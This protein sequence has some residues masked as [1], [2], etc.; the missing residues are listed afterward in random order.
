M[1]LDL[2]AIARVGGNIERN[3]IIERILSS[4]G[5]PLSERTVKAKG[6]DHSWIETG[7]ALSSV[8]MVINDAGEGMV[9]SAVGFFNPGILPR[10]L[11]N[12]YG[13]KHIPERSVIRWSHE[14]SKEEAIKAMNEEAW[15]QIKEIFWSGQ[16]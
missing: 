1:P 2:V 16:K 3:T 11:A 12:E 15:R 10:V 9:Y 5:P 13:T 4:P 8:E 14:Q 6:H 7:E